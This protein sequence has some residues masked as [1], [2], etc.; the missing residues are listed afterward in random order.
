MNDR[1]DLE[2]RWADE[3]E[4]AMDGGDWER[5]LEILEAAPFDDGVRWLLSGGLWVEL[6]ELER[7]A[8]DLAKAE[9]LLGEGDPDVLRAK[10]RLAI[11]RWDFEEATHWL[12]YLDPGDWGGQLLYDNSFVADATGDHDRAHAL[13]EKAHALEP[14]AFPRPL[15]LS[16][17]EF[18][19]AVRASAEELPE[20]F[21]EV[22]EEVAVVIDPMPTQEVVGRE[23]PP[24]VLGLFVGPPVAEREAGVGG[25]LPPT[26]FL[27][28]RNLERICPTLEELRREIEITL[29]HELGHALGFDED[30]VDEMGLG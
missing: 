16:P 14:D 10:A 13:L 4:Q 2:R 23:H 26:I 28:Q 7:A 19:R 15:R 22:F 1:D 20:E 9:H 8:E 25:E 30:G 17:D 12:S 5:A 21:R 27:F 24:D 11:A 18:E 29:Y 6:D 3:A